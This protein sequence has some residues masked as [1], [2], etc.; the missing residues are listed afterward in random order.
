MAN[1]GNNSF[2]HNGQRFFE[3]IGDSSGNCDSDPKDR[4]A[5]GVVPSAG[6]RNQQRGGFRRFRYLGTEGTK[7]LK[8]TPLL[9]VE[10]AWIGDLR[11][12]FLRLIRLSE[13]LIRQ[14][15]YILWN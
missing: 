10:E 8:K 3:R 13:D 6:S 4:L 15:L 9:N 7:M 12:C 14:I 11:I 5:S 2:R 1:S